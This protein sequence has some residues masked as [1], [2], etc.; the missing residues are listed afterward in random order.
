VSKGAKILT[1]GKRHELGRSFFEPTVLSDV[2]ADMMPFKCE[3]FG[4]LAPVCRFSTEEEA[5][6]MAN[7][8]IHGLAAYFYSQGRA[9]CWR[10]AEALQAGIVCENTVAFSSARAPFGGYKESGIGRDGGHEGLEEWQ[11]VKYRCLGGIE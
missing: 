3:I 4:P 9:R 8:T 10:V 6:A 5:I 1:G 11:D 2:S 7:D